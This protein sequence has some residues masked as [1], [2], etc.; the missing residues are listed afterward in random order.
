MVCL[1]ENTSTS[2]SIK[3][4]LFFSKCTNVDSKNQPVLFVFAIQ[5]FKGFAGFRLNL[6]KYSA[7]PAEQE[8][9]LKEGFEV[10]VLKV[11]SVKVQNQCVEASDL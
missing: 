11:E 5:N 6:D 10:H 1:P 9:I 7:Y 8:V 2:Y 4:A 3:E